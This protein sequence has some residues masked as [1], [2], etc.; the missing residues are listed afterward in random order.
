MCLPLRSDH[1][2]AW[3]YMTPTRRVVHYVYIIPPDPWG[4]MNEMGVILICAC[5]KCVSMFQ[6]VSNMFQN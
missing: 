5:V 3:L 6:A 1:L 2:L 4:F